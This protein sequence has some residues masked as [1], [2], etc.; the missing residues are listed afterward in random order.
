[1]EKIN[2]HGVTPSV[3][4]LPERGKI[5]FGFVDNTFLPD[6]V[7][8]T[9]ATCRSAKVPSDMVFSFFFDRSSDMVLGTNEAR[10]PCTF[11][12]RRSI[13]PAHGVTVLVMLAHRLSS[14]WIEVGKNEDHGR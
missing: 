1:M 4:E 2:T 3:I 7:T 5:L 12:L 14:T 9:D 10:T 6:V 11:P 13:A 8:V